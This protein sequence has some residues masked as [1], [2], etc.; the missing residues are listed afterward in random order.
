MKNDKN[1]QDMPN[2]I[3]AEMEARLV[4]WVSGE[5]SPAE[6]AELERLAGGNPALAAGQGRIEA[7]RALAAQAMAPDSAPLRMSEGRRAA[8]LR[9]LG[10][11]AAAPARAA[12]GTAEVPDL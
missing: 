4:A 10:A 6:S 11:P 1:D 5:A 8:L 9:E 2:R 7:A 3:S 12:T